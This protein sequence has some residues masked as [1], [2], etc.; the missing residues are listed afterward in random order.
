[1]ARVMLE[2][3]FLLEQNKNL[4]QMV[5][6]CDSISAMNQVVISEKDLQLML[7]DRQ[8]Q[9]QALIIGLQDDKFN[10]AEKQI[11]KQ[12]A[13]KHLFLGTTVL[14]AIVLTITLVK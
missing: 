12:S 10:A 13:M 7:K 6:W 3:T 1:M 5:D 11:S 9:D 8:I 2:Y 4:M 14:A